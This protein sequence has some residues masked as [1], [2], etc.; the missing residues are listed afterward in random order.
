MS[1]FDPSA[2]ALTA[3]QL[4]T[5][6]DPGQFGFQSTAEIEG[7]GEVIGQTRALDAMRFGA[8]IRHEGY[9]IFVLGPAG[10]GKHSLVRQFLE[11]KA[12]DEPDPADWCYLNNF[13][14]PHRSRA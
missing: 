8:G 13:E 14:Q 9:N 3:Q 7:L 2:L 11:K 4:H 5:A 10:L 1:T 12:H 6:C